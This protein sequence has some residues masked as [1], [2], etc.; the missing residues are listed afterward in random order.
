MSEAR[1]PQMTPVEILNAN[2]PQIP[3]VDVEKIARELGLPIHRRSDLTSDV[4]GM[5][6]K[7]RRHPSPSGFAIHVNANDNLRRQRFT[8]AH[9]IAHYILHR[10]LIGDGITDDA[11]YRSSLG[12]IYERQANRMAADILMPASLLRTYYR[13]KTPA[14]A[15]LAHA[16][17]VSMEAMAI[18]LNELRLGP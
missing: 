12:D 17:D 13:E 2:T 8:I 7:D 18:R 10:D 4:A 3:P 1:L 9:E 5:I 15:P 11:L 14:I 6:I 16:F